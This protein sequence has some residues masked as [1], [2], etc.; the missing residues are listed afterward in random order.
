MKK[1]RITARLGQGRNGESERER[2]R[3]RERESVGMKR[4]GGRVLLGSHYKEL[5]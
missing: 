1:V 3:E 4:L 5:A 2:E